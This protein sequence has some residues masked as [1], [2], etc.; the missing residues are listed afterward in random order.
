MQLDKDTM[1]YSAIILV[2][3]RICNEI[4]F[5]V[6]KEHYLFGIVTV[7]IRYSDFV[8]QLK[9][10]TIKP[11]DNLNDLNKVATELFISNVEQG[12]A[13]RKVGVRI[14]GLIKAAKQ[15]RL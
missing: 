13:V 1:E 10:R 5:E 12:R 2:F 3:N 4:I 14:S 7:K 6:Q 9:S 8:D 15:K 11:S